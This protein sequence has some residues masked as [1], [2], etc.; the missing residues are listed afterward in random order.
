MASPITVISGRLKEAGPLTALIQNRSY[1]S[2]PTDNC[3]LPYVV[4]LRVSGGDG[5]NLGGPRRLSQHDIRVEAYAET[6]QQAEEVLDAVRD[7]LHGWRDRTIGV[8][9]CFAQG[10]ADESTEDDGNQVSGQTF[11]LHFCPQ[12]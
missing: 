7:Q 11:S 8:Q 3:P 5:M 1:P 6:E 12:P 2:K 4:Y 10:D 9:G